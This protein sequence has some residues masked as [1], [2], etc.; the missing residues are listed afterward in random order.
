MVFIQIIPRIQRK[1][2]CV[3]EL[4]KGADVV[5]IQI[6]HRILRKEALLSSSVGSIRTQQLAQ[7]F[8]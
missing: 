5:F 3:L 1:E 2:L 7:A 6:F 8:K 4:T